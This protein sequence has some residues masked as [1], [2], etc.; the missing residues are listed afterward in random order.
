[1]LLQTFAL[2]LRWQ[3]M[4]DVAPIFESGRAVRE[5]ASPHDER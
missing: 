5:P 1:M 3:G 4:E 2:D